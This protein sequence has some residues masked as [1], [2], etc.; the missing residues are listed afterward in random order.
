MSSVRSVLR[1]EKY[2]QHAAAKLMANGNYT[3]TMMVL[4]EQ[5]VLGRGRVP[6]S[7]FA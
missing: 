5:V 4:S 6:V 1:T 2:V 7:L 3:A